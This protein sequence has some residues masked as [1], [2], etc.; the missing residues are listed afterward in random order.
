VGWVLEFAGGED[1][2][3]DRGNRAPNLGKR[4]NSRKDRQGRRVRKR[5]YSGEESP[6]HLKGY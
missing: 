5:K 2:L 6:L 4:E 3:G 1:D